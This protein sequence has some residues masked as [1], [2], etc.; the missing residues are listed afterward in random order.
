MD[1][2]LV[3]TDQVEATVRH[4]EADIRELEQLQVTLLGGGCAEVIFG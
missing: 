1:F 3:E 4:A 2:N